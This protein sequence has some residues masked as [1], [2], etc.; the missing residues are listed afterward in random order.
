MGR[1][2]SFPP[3]F[4]QAARTLLLVAHRGASAAGKS[5]AGAAQLARLPRE[6][7]L[8]VLAHAAYPL[9]AWRPQ[10]EGGRRELIWHNS[11]SDGGSSS[12]DGLPSSDGG[13]PSG[14]GSLPSGGGGLPNSDGL[15]SSDGGGSADASGRNSEEEVSSD[16][17]VSA[18]S[19][20]FY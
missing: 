18:S 4:R 3:A 15:P 16:R 10:M 12:S 9:S 20:P 19:E 14:D 6:L 2:A 8:V 1:H 7:L 5:S 17:T 13:A 11:D